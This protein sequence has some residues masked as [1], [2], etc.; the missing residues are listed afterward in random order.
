MKATMTMKTRTTLNTRLLKLARHHR[1]GSRRWSVPGYSNGIALLP[2][3]GH[4]V[5]AWG[6]SLRWPGRDDKG[7]FVRT[8]DLSRHRRL[9][10]QAIRALL[11]TVQ[12]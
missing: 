2:P 7:E 12:G 5:M 8:V 4:G 10:K 6:W 1:D 11:A 9:A 3:S